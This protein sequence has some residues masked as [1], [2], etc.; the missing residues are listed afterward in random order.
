M[1]RSMVGRRGVMGV[2]N[3]GSGGR[4]SRRGSSVGDARRVVRGPMAVGRRCP[5]V[6]DVR[7]VLIHNLG[8]AHH[9]PPSSV[10]VGPHYPSSTPGAADVSRNSARTFF[11][12][13]LYLYPYRLFSI[14]IFQY[15]GTRNVI[16]VITVTQYK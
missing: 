1:V 11:L 12:F 5:L 13:L 4:S 10:A 9:H 15:T 8:A 14:Q 2:G 6:G 16:T 3:G 7:V